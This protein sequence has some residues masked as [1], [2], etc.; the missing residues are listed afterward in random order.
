MLLYSCFVRRKLPKAVGQVLGVLQSRTYAK[1][2]LESRS[3]AELKGVIGG[4]KKGGRGGR[5]RKKGG[6]KGLKQSLMVPLGQGK[7]GI[8]WPGLSHTLQRTRYGSNWLQKDELGAQVDADLAGRGKP[9]ELFLP[10]LEG[11][12]SVERRLSEMNWSRK[13]WSGRLWAGRYVGCPESPDGK[14]LT[15]FR[16]IVMELKRVSNQTKGGK[17]RTVS[18]LVVVG[19]GNGVAGF[20]VGR[21]EETKAA[22]RKAKNKAVNYLQMIPRLENHTMYHNVLVKYCRTTVKME[23]GIKGSGL[24]C[25]RSIASVCELAGLKDGRVKVIGSTNPLNLV[26]ATFKALTN[27]ETHQTLAEKSGKFLVEFNRDR[28]F[29]PIIVASTANN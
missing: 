28:D 17:K 23:R 25:H 1:N 18:A 20:A 6:K 7:A 26:R 4:G 5:G 9:N 2:P 11:D 10:R 29:R 15:S 22:I 12:K 16:S 3:M 21:S 14:P 13:G 8:T 19:N 27:Q 24:R